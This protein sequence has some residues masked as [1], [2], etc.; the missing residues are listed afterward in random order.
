[1]DGEA[2]SRDSAVSLSLYIFVMVISHGQ[3]LSCRAASM[4]RSPNVAIEPA[5]C[6][7]LTNVKKQI[8]IV[9][10]QETYENDFMKVIGLT[11]SKFR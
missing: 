11:P 1:M 8:N 5:T 9:V 3:T 2:G 6:T 10:A 7:R 4:F